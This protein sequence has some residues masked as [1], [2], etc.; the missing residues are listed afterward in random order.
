MGFLE[1]LNRSR[2][3]KRAID[4]GVAGTGLFVLCPALGVVSILVWQKHGRPVLFRQQRPGEAG[5]IFELV[6]FRTMTNERT[7]GGELLP[8]ERRLTRFGKWLRATSIDE[9]PELW[10]VL[11][12]DMSLVG[13]RPLLV[14]YLELYTDEQRRRHEMPPGITGWAQVH[15][16]NLLTW[17][18]KFAMDVWY[19]DNWSIRLDL[20]V[21]LQTA[22]AVLFREGISPEDEAIMPEFRGSQPTVG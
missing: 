21:L 20:E 3:L 9:L 16:R 5:R 7:Q 22:R 13:P 14:K 18:E 11:R 6:K 17:E 1:S 2:R 15:G 19:V 4:I 8:A 12:G 10:N